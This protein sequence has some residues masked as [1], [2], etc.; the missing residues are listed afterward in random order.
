MHGII[1][2]IDPKTQSG[3]IQ[4]DDGRILSFALS[5]LKAEVPPEASMEVLFELNSEDEAVNIVLRVAEDFYE[6]KIFMTEPEKIGLCREGIPD[7]YE[8]VDRASHSI[9]TEHRNLTAAKWAL[10]NFT[11]ECGGNVVLKFSETKFIKNSIGFSLNYYRV[12]GILAIIGHRVANAELTLYDLKRR[13]NHKK[14]DDKHNLEL[15]VKLG[16]KIITIIGGI[17]MMIFILGF[18]FTL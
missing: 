10:I 11:H 18:L 8:L 17:L 15:N 6:S 5:D 7:G 9:S 14:L 4:S 13:L 16:K 2:T 12:S 3:R 1:T